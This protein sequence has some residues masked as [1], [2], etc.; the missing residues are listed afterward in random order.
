MLSS[1]LG[2][3]GEV[4]QVSDKDA[5]EIMENVSHG[6]LEH[7][8]YI[9]ESKRHNTIRKSAPWGGKCGFVLICWMDLDLIVARE[10]IHE[11]HS[12]MACT[13]IDNLVDERRWEVVFGTSM[14]E[15][16]KVSTDTNSALF[17][18]NRG[19]VGDP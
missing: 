5:S 15:I 13:V 18:V 1:F 17:I 19:G 2:A 12:L 10:A 14:I 8:T 11:G 3:S 6:L 7:R 4:V 9:F 16:A